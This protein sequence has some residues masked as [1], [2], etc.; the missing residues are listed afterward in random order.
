[1]GFAFEGGRGNGVV[2]RFK[3]VL[4]GRNVYP[5]PGVHLFMC[6]DRRRQRAW[7]GQVVYTHARLCAEMTWMV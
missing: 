7:Y 4:A 3:P 6:S 1:M 2:D 5:A